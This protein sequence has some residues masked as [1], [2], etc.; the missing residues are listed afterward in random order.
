MSVATRVRKCPGR[1]KK[2]W[3]RDEK[4]AMAGA[5]WSVRTFKMPC[6]A[7]QCTVKGCGGW[8]LTKRMEER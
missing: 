6:R 5:A 8:H 3:Y 1:V 7:Y 2:H 4:A